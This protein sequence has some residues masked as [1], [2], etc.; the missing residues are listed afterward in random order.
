M[1]FG[2]C[3]HGLALGPGFLVAWGLGS[4]EVF[5]VSS[6]CLSPCDFVVENT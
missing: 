2:S 5:G 1:S 4:K 6:G 3:L